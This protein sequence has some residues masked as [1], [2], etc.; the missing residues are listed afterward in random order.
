MKFRLLLVLSIFSF[1][2]LK[3][4]DLRV[5]IDELSSDLS[6]YKIVDVRSAD[7]FKEGHIK[8]ALNLPIKFTYDNKAISGKIT[9]PNKMQEILRNLGLDVKD[10]IVVYDDGTFFDSARLFWT[11][12][13]Y[14]FKNVK[15]LNGGYDEWDTLDL[16]TSTKAI[17]PKKSNYIASI[18]N[19][20]LA[21]KFATQ[22]ATRS[23]TQTIIDARGLQ[24]YEGKVSSAKRYGHIPSAKHIPAT[25]N[26]ASKSG[27]AKLKSI[28]ELEKTYKGVDKNKKVVLYCAIGRIS[29]TN[30]F[31]MREL[32]YDVANYDAS[33]KE[34]G[35]DFNL[36]INNPSAK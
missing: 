25:H 14:G 33:W 29:S 17:T 16:P 6:S 21:T 27:I 32:G 3:A 35:N 12:E 9:P 22:I 26:I 30:Y 24:A 10:Q 11:L 31:A 1:M 34:W 36:P 7:L 18:D 5:Q 19:K 28:E 13:V 8:G 23:T 4:E 2:F 15:L 20:R